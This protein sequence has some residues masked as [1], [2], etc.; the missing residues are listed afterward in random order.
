MPGWSRPSCSASATM[1]RAIRSLTLPPGL[2]NSHLPRTGTGR[3]AATLW[4][5]TSGVL[6]IRSRIEEK[7]LT[8]SL[9]VCE[10]G[11]GS[12]GD[13]TVGRVGVADLSTQGFRVGYRKLYGQLVSNVP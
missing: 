6:P 5:R 11:A 1:A 10:A 9:S 12:L 8:A 7:A 3:P 4:R 13:P 2:R